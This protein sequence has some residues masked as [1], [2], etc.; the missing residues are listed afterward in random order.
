MSP[1]REETYEEPLT[2]EI[3]VVIALFFS[4]ASP[5]SLRDGVAE[6]DTERQ[7]QTSRH[8][9]TERG[10]DRKTERGTDRKT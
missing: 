6:G 4:F 8:R 3:D 10:T 5:R 2:P 9:Q 1:A 7:T